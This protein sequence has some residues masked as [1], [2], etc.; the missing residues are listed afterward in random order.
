MERTLYNS[1]VTCEMKE[2]MMNEYI[3]KTNNKLE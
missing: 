3:I 2:V 1:A